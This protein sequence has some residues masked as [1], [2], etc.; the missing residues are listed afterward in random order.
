MLQ[1]SPS[2]PKSNKLNRHQKQKK[3]LTVISSRYAGVKC[4][5][6]PEINHEVYHAPENQ[7]RQHFQ[8]YRK[9]F[10]FHNPPFFKLEYIVEDIPQL[11]EINDHILFILPEFTLPH[12]SGSHL[13]AYFLQHFFFFFFR[14]SFDSHQSTLGCFT[15]IASQVSLL[16][17]LV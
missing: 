12:N 4:N 2:N 11:V 3:A 14:N 6:K 13:L 10:C 17:V 7:H 8:N 9:L 5:N 15:V 1:N 16:V